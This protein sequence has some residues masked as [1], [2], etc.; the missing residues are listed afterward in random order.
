MTV[1]AVRS[2]VAS[3]PHRRSTLIQVKP[4]ETSSIYHTNSAKA[5]RDSRFGEE[6]VELFE[7]PLI[8]VDLTEELEQGREFDSLPESFGRPGNRGQ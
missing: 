6:A 3:R 1:A 8:R 2:A 7:S 4:W 5:D